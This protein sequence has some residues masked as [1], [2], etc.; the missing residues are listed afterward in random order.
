M[1]EI[2]NFIMS[3]RRTGKNK[4]VFTPAEIVDFLSQVLELDEYEV[5][6]CEATN[7]SCKIAIG[8]SVYYLTDLG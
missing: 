5:S 1:N 2:K 3:K 8:E 6:L 7:K 4:F